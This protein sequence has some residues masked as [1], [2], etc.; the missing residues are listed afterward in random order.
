M[1]ARAAVGMFYSRVTHRLDAEGRLRVD[2]LLGDKAAK[3]EIERR[4]REQIDALAADGL[5]EVR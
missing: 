1:S 2:A 5:I 4:E 3:A